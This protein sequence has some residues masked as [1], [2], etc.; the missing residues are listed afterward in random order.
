MVQ[1]T[2]EACQGN[3]NR[4]QWLEEG[5]KVDVFFKDLRVLSETPA[6]S[7]EGKGTYSSEETWGGGGAQGMHPASHREWAL[8]L[9]ASSS[10]GSPHVVVTSPPP[11]Q[12]Q[13][14]WFPEDPALGHV[15]QLGRHAPS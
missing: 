13:E 15:V 4:G 12:D 14:T 3:L 7:A 10:A 2:P 8:C 5:S 11:E 1:A 6:K 9:I